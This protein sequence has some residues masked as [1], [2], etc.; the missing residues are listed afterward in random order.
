[1]KPAYNSMQALDNAIK[2]HQLEAKI[3]EKRTTLETDD[4]RGKTRSYHAQ[5]VVGCC[6]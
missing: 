2:I 3:A 4:P 5:N 1:M 6:A